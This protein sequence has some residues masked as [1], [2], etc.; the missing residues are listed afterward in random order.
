MTQSVLLTGGFGYVGG[1]VTRDL[2]RNSK[3]DVT[4]T[5]RNPDTA[6]VPEW[7]SRE[8]CAKLDMLDDNSIKNVCKNTDIIIHFAALNEIDS[9]RDPEAA[10]LINSLGTMKL[11][12]A[13]EKA[14]VRRF[15]YFSTAHVYG[16]PLVGF[17]SESTIPHPVHPYAITHRAAEDFVL[18]SN[19]NKT[20]TGIVLRLSNSIGAPVN[21][22]VNRWSLAGNDLCRQAVISREIRLKTPGLQKR[23]FIGLD[24][25]ARGV[26]HMIYLPEPLLGDGI[27]NFGGEN[28]LSVFDLAFRIQ[29]RCT[30]LLRYTP[31]MVRP[32]PRGSDR[33]EELSYSIE[34]LKSTGFS[35]QGSLD[36]E[37]DET[38]L[39]CQ[40]HIREL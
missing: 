34:K 39:F 5:T 29:N 24:D 26:A 37:I 7:L 3:F 17:I 25:V 27:F 18:A 35:L 11:V 14:G 40:E 31:Q 32:E 16:S 38:L 36:Q 30:E 19:I 23:D 13:A 4:V 10:F 20:M 15:I 22:R 33:S 1:R 28:V 8:Q 21:A 6:E 2:C 9:V 12:T